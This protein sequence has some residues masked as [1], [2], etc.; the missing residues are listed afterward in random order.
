MRRMTTLL[1][2]CAAACVL[3]PVEAGAKGVSAAKV[4]GATECTGH[5]GRDLAMSMSEGGPTTL[6]P[7]R[8]HP[9]YRT[10]LTVRAPEESGEDFVDHFSVVAVPAAHRLC[11]EDGTWM[12][13]TTRQ[14]RAYAKLTVGIAPKPARTLPGMGTATATPAHSAQPS[15]DDDSSPWLRMAAGGLVALGLVGVALR[16]RR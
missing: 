15:E 3:A 10:T 1:A 4:C 16:L 12:E 9:W 6:A 11:A 7:K 14:I 13:M 8:R 5:I 2:L